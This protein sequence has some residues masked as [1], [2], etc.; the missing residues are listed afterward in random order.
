MTDSA[1]AGLARSAF[2]LF[3]YIG[4]HTFGIMETVHVG[5]R[6]WVNL[7]FFLLFLGS[8]YQTVEDSKE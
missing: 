5:A 1:N 3:A 4:M 8:G 6:L 2:V 7:A